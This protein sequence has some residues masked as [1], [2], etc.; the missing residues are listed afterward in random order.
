MAQFHEDFRAVAG[1]CVHYINGAI[2][3]DTVEVHRVRYGPHS[4]VKSAIWIGIG[5]DCDKA[6][7]L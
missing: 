7:R 2:A 1:V 6:F 3:G 5:N 4:G